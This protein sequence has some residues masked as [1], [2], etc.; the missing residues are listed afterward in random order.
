MPN[1]WKMM[2]VTP[3]VKVTGTNTATI[4]RV[5]AS[6]ESATS[7][8]PRLAACTG[9]SPCSS[10]W[11]MFSRTTIASSITRPT[12][13]EI[14]SS[15][16]ML[17]DRPNSAMPAKVPR[18][19]TGRPI[20]VMKVLRSVKAACSTSSAT[21]STIAYS[22]LTSKPSAG[23][24][25]TPTSSTSAGRSEERS[26]RRSPLKNSITTST[27]KPSA[28][29]ISSIAPRTLRRTSLASLRTIV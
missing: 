10:R 28:M 14:A 24:S 1:D 6:T 18:M 4:V 3:V 23:S 25:T 27:A 9:V 12:E 15:V 22:S 26:A 19:I 7:A 5:I 16:M 17:S 11:M 13:T 20:T 29:K 8:V 2:P 21:A